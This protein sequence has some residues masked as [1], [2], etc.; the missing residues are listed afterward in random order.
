MARSHSDV[1]EAFG[2]CCERG[3]D[4]PGCRGAQEGE[5]IGCDLE[6]RP[7]VYFVENVPPCIE[8][9]QLEGGLRFSLELGDRR[10]C[11]R[12]RNRGVE[13]ERVGDD[14]HCHSGS[15]LAVALVEDAAQVA[16]DVGEAALSGVLDGLGGGLH[17]F[18]ENGHA[19]VDEALRHHRV[20]DAPGDLVDAACEPSGFRPAVRFGGVAGVHAISEFRDGDAFG[21]IGLILPER[22]GDADGDS[23]LDRVGGHAWSFAEPGFGVV[24]DRGRRVVFGFDRD[25]LRVDDVDKHVWPCSRGVPQH[26]GLLDVEPVVP[27]RVLAAENFGEHGIECDF[28]GVRHG[29]VRSIVQRKENKNA[30]DGS[31]NLAS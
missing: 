6:Y 3:K 7:V 9:A 10:Y 20:L 24:L 2:C 5:K 4:A 25:R 31:M 30:R 15:L 14:G 1:G 23:L 18:L 16:F 22:L 29:V 17:S 13:G 27:Q 12:A 21:Q 8:K 26:P 11:M 19:F 28:A